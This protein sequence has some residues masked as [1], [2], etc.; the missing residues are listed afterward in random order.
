MIE[1]Q[2]DVF[3]WSTRARRNMAWKL[4]DRGTLQDIKHICENIA[5]FIKAWQ[6]SIVIPVKGQNE[7][8]REMGFVGR[9]QSQAI[10]VSDQL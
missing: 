5:C 7:G 2:Q 1:D 10:N 8:E 3:T 9:L 4:Q 6:I